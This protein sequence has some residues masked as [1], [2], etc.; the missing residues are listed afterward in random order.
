MIDL[1][2]K[3]AEEV[4]ALIQK[5]ANVVQLFKPEEQPYFA[6]IIST[7]T[8]YVKEKYPEISKDWKS[9]AI[10]TLIKRV[11]NVSSDSDIKVIIDA[12]VVHYKNYYNDFGNDLVW[13]SEYDKEH[14][15]VHEYLNKKG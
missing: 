11:I 3:S 13:A 8:D 7:G 12:F 1:I 2:N 15:F 9:W 10:M 14:K 5:Y 4:N 6:Y